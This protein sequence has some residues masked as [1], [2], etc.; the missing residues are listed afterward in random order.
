MGQVH[1]PRSLFRHMRAFRRAANRR[2]HAARVTAV[3]LCAL[4]LAGCVPAA[5]PS[6][7]PT[8]PIS[9]TPT[10]PISAAPGPSST[11]SGPPQP[12]AAPSAPPGWRLVWSDE[13]S[14]DS[15]DRSKWATLDHSTFG[16]A[17]GE[18]ACLLSRNVSVHGGLLTITAERPA[19]PVHC[20]GYD[21]RFPHGRRYTTGFVETK[22][23]AAFQYGRF[24]IRA[25]MPTAPGA[26]KGLWPA[27]WLRPAS[28]GR[29]EL[30]VLELTGTSPDSLAARNLVR[31]TIHDDYAGRHE[32]E[33]VD[34]P[35]P[36]GNPDTGFHTFAAEWE[37]GSIRWYVDGVPT[38]SRTAATTPWLD[39]AFTGPF[40]LRINL[41]VGGGWA[42]TPDSS[43]AFPA[44][45]AVDWVRVYQR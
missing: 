32:P 2:R 24:E 1:V 35:L 17:N 26:S 40:F 20:G 42:G 43:T 15:L 5:S 4:A 9:S 39:E 31:Q 23:R 11:A 27:F 21:H 28:L 45:Y 3:A 13:F 18:L 41:A 14:G 7:T 37:P 36:E 30:D 38:F 8:T 19:K 34:Y 44:D 12:A 33:W 25:R 29:G 22:D 10:T 6:S 16:D